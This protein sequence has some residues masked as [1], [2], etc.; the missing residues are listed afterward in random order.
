LSKLINFELGKEAMT[1]FHHNKNVEVMGFVKSAN[2]VTP[3]LVTAVFKCSSCGEL[4]VQDQG[5]GKCRLLRPEICSNQSCSSS[6]PKFLFLHDKSDY[7]DYQEIWLKPN[8]Q[9]VIK[10]GRGQKII[11]KNDLVGAKEGQRVKITGKVG[12]ELIGRT[13]F[14]R[15][16]VYATKLKKLKKP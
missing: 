8:D 13:T 2:P 3:E 5:G 6:K 7:Q 11:L 9:P 1:T 15:P 16:V 12:F 4:I 10:M 14:A